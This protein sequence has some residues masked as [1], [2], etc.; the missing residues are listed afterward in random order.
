MRECM[1]RGVV[2]NSDLQVPNPLLAGGAA[3]GRGLSW[4]ASLP[5]LCCNEGSGIPYLNPKRGLGFGVQG[6]GFGPVFTY[7]G[8]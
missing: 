5:K 7:L 2:N 1:P 4:P 6:L 3:E 8:V